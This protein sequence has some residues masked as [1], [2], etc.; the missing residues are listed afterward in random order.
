MK[1]LFAALVLISAVH[2]NAACEGE[3]QFIGTVANHKQV[4][5]KGIV[6]HCTF[7]INFSLYNESMVCPLSNGE[8]GTQ[9]DKACSLKNG[10]SVPGGPLVKKGSKV[11]IERFND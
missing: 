8:V 1:A 6:T 9:I 4:V 2:A 3:A 7:N 11:V 10:D 5:D